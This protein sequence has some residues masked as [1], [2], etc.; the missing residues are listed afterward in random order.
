MIR[1][2]DVIVTVKRGLA[3]V[4]VRRKELLAEL[5]DYDV[6]DLSESHPAYWVDENGRPCARNYVVRTSSG[7][8]AQA[9][10]KHL[11][12]F[13][14]DLGYH[15]NLKTTVNLSRDADS[16]HVIQIQGVDFYFYA[17]G[18]GY[19]GWGRGIQQPGGK[20]S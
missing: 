15:T 1:S 18:T 11:E 9:S 16:L 5:R 4:D 13:A 2:P 3:T 10:G 6:A 7:P 20:R 19:D 12:R 8:L 17:N 14:D